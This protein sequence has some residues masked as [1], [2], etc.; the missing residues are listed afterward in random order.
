M[1]ELITVRLSP[2]WAVLLSPGPGETITLMMVVCVFLMVNRAGCC[3]AQGHLSR[4][5]SNLRDDPEIGFVMGWVR[6]RS[7]KGQEKVR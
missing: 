3:Q 7:G 5:T 1:V 6:E 4:Q 2:A